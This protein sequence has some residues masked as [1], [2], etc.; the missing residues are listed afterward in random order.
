MG[1]NRAIVDQSNLH[2][3]LK[4]AVLDLLSRI[5][6]LYFAVEVL[7]QLL[8]IISTHCAVEIWL[9][10]LLCRREK[11]ELRHCQYRLELPLATY[12]E[13]EH[14][15]RIELRRQCPE[16]SSSTTLNSLERFQDKV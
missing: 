1:A 4:H 15:H 12:F 8:S 16:R 7:V 14:P 5:P 3:G 13:A 10:A 11:R 9:V 2:H 6:R